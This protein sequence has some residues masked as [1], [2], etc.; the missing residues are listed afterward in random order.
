MKSFL[1]A[2]LVAAMLVPAAAY[3]KK[4]PD[5]QSLPPVLAV[6][7]APAKNEISGGVSVAAVEVIKYLGATGK[8]QMITFNPALPVVARA[9]L[10]RRLPG[11]VEK[12]IADPAI[13]TQVAKM[14]GAS[15]ALYINPS[16]AQDAGQSAGKKVV[17]NLSLLK[18]EG[19]KWSSRAESNVAEGAGTTDDAR[20]A[21]AASTAA[22]AA[23]SGLVIQAFGEDS[24]FVQPDNPKV[25]SALDVVARVSEPVRNIDEEYAQSMAHTDEYLSSDDTGNAVVELKRS[26]ALKPLRPEPRVKLVNL[27]LKLGMD[28]AARDECVRALWF[29]PDDAALR[30][31]LIKLSLNSGSLAEAA[32]QCREIIR[33]DPKN[34]DAHLSLGD[35]SWN[36]GNP[37][38]AEA[39]YK[40]A[41]ALDPGNPA[42]HEKLHNLY[43]ARKNYPSA[44]A[45]LYQMKLLAGGSK[46]PDDALAQTVK[47][48]FNDVL[49][50]LDSAG[51]DY[52]QSRMP[53]EDYYQECKDLGTRIDTF[54]K[55]LSAQ[56]V[57]VSGKDAYTH[58]AYAVS[59]LSQAAS[60]S[61]TYLETE[62]QNYSDQAKLL[63][64]EARN[65][66][67]IYTRG[68][69]NRG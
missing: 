40:N 2:F 39:A 52:R 57:P 23:V 9:V 25:V 5:S 6:F 3:A 47:D 65:E 50:K 4:N 24:P 11:D 48:E 44:V 34:V 28:A 10:E 42:P 22:S 38:G 54:D 7:G 14:M 15:Y 43:L 58:A 13:E 63:R 26:I 35:I 61:V 45:E 33:L 66:F 27:Y 12:R 67:A 55:F 16:V 36:Q 30:K 49:G 56:S 18:L 59:L 8:F 46:A 69:S 20:I 51:E 19:G 53:R 60:Y 32:E 1:I 21:M 62:K 31:T 17:V 29:S 37:E 68:V 41:A 64:T